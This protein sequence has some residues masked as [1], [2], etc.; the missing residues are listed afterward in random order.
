MP[1]LSGR[2]SAWNS[3]ADLASIWAAWVGPIHSTLQIKNQ[4]LKG[5]K[6]APVFTQLLS[7]RGGIRS[8]LFPGS[9]VQCSSQRFWQL[10]WLF[11][12][13]P[14]VLCAFCLGLIRFCMSHLCTRIL[15]YSKITAILT[16]YYVHEAFQ[17]LILMLFSRPWDS[18]CYSI[19]IEEKR[20]LRGIK[21]DV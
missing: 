17:M 9:Q 16:S 20:T 18:Y 21:Y 19:L 13:V 7:D 5:M 11:L 4:R 15:E 8:Q 1:P 10:Q 6:K 14:A 3:A 12:C 2:L